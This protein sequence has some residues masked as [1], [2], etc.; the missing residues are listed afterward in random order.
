MKLKLNVTVKYR[1]EKCLAGTVIDVQQEDVEEMKKY[2]EVVLLPFEPEPNEC[3]KADLSDENNSKD[4]NLD[5][6]QKKPVRRNTVA[7]KTT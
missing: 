6:V 7:K 4:K 1:N 2:G 5:E 3:V